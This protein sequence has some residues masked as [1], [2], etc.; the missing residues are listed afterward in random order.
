MLFHRGGISFVAVVAL[1]VG[2]LVLSACDTAPA[3]YSARPL[4]PVVTSTALQPTVEHAQV[5]LYLQGV[6]AQETL[7]AVRALQ[8]ATAVSGQATA[9]AWAWQATATAASGQATATAQARA[10]EA[11][12]TARADFATATAN[13]VAWQQAATATRAAW[14]SQAT[15]TRTAYNAIATAQAAGAERARLEAE[16]ARLTYPVRAYGP[17]VFLVVSFALLIWGG[18]RVILAIEMRLRAIPRD[19]RG[20]APVLVLPRPGGG[21][22]I[23]D[24]DRSFWPVIE[25]DQEV[26][27]P[28]LAPPEYQAQV[29]ARDQAVDLVS[30]GITG[31]P[32]SY[33]RGLPMMGSGGLR[34]IMVLRRLDQGVAAGVLPPPMAQALEADW[35]RAQEEEQ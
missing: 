13:A 28:E 11:T 20:D 6:K 21:A 9:T 10:A 2:L 25:A 32:M 24:A 22:R 35:R 3:S 18:R 8:T 33:Q 19:A 5:E 17:W 27:S 34:R 26:R 30:R 15:A 7:E 12:A 29:T 31:A 1:I 14:E 16:R 4:P 23:I